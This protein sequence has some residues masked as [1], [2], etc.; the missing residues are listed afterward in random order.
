MADPGS[1]SRGGG[2]N[3]QKMR[4]KTVKFPKKFLKNIKNLSSGGGDHPFAPPTAKSTTDMDKYKKRSSGE[5]SLCITNSILRP[6]VSKIK[7]GPNRKLITFR[8]ESEKT[9]LC[10]TRSGFLAT[11]QKIFLKTKLSQVH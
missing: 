9:R 7:N 6:L 11:D 5:C 2:A 4:L 10:R 3:S 8:G 1:T